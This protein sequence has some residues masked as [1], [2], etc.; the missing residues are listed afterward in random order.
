MLGVCSLSVLGCSMSHCSEPIIWGERARI[1]VVQT[2]NL[3]GLLGIRRVDKVPN[4]RIRELRVASKG[5]KKRFMKVFFDVERMEKDRIAKSVYVGEYPQ[6]VGR[7][8][9]GLI[10]GRTA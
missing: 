3:R 2:D 9:G 8:K 10:P 1:R 5:E 6:W 4:A 7:G